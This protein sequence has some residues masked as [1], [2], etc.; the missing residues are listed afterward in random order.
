MR[1]SKTGF[2]GNADNDYFQ[3]NKNLTSITALPQLNWTPV[4]VSYYI[5]KFN[6]KNLIY[7][8]VLNLSTT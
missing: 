1:N 2:K 8:Y 5:F 6:V 3:Q 4:C 7:W